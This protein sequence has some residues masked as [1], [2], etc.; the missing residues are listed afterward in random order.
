MTTPS[1]CTKCT[2]HRSRRCIVR[3]TIPDG[4]DVLFVGEA[5][6]AVEEDERKPFVG[7]AGAYLRTALLTA[8][9]DPNK[10]AYANSVRCRPPLRNRRQTR[11]TPKQ[12]AVCHDFLA[13]DVKRLKPKLIVALGAPA[14]EA[15]HRK[16]TIAEAR[17]APFACDQFGVPTIVTYHPSGVMQDYSDPELF[18]ADLRRAAQIASGVVDTSKPAKLGDYTVIAPGDGY[19]EKQ[20]LAGLQ[21]LRDYLLK[22]KR[23]SFDIESEGTNPR[24]HR[25]LCLS[26]STKPGEG[27]VVPLV[28]RFVECEGLSIEE[29]VKTIGVGGRT[30]RQVWSAKALE[31]VVE[32]LREI[33]ESDVPKT[34]Q[35][36][37]FD[38]RFC[39]L[40]LEIDVKAFDY[41]T[42]LA[43]HTYHS[44]RPHT[45]EHLRDKYTDMPQYDMEL[46]RYAP[47]RKHSF[48][49][50]PEEVLWMYSA[51][52]ADCEYQLGDA[53][54]KDMH[55]GPYANEA[56]EW[57]LNEISM[58]LQRALGDA[59]DKGIPVDEVYVAKLAQQVKDRIVELKAKLDR[60]IV[61][62]ELEPPKNYGSEQQLN[63]LFYSPAKP[64]YLCECRRLFYSPERLA[65]HLAWAEE[66]K[67]AGHRQKKHWL[68]GLGIPRDEGAMPRPGYDEKQTS[69]ERYHERI[70]PRRSTTERPVIAS[71][72]TDLKTLGNLLDLKAISRGAKRVL[73]EIIDLKQVEKLKS[74]FIGDEKQTKGWIRFVE[75]GW[76]H[77]TF[78][79]HGTETSRL[80]SAG[81]NVQNPPSAAV[82]RNIVRAKEGFKLVDA[83]YSQVENRALAYGARS[84]TYV[85]DMLSCATCGERYRY[86]PDGL[87]AHFVETQH[88][89]L[90][91]HTAGALRIF[92]VTADQV[93]PDIRF[94]AK[95]FTHGVNYGRGPS[96]VSEAF[97][98]SF[99]SAKEQIKDYFEKYPDIKRFHDQTRV[100]LDETSMALTYLGRER[101]F[102]TWRKLREEQQRDGRG[103]ARRTIGLI[104]HIHREAI[105]TF[106]Q[107]SAAELL[108]LATIGLFDWRG[109][110]E[111][112]D[113]VM[114]HRLLR[115]HFGEYPALVMQHEYGAHMAISMHDSL[116]SVAP[117]GFAEKV[118]QMVCD[119]M[120]RIPL[121]VIPRV[122][123]PRY[124]DWPEGW[125][126]PVDAKIHERYGTDINPT[127]GELLGRDEDL[128]VKEHLERSRVTIRASK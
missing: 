26:F 78:N 77:P 9:F 76:L 14:L 92:N 112:G 73:N 40:Q 67:E 53:T 55:E 96:A 123:S 35:L 100:W 126:L 107:G 41:D 124:G 119:V 56:A 121:L 31:R 61:K 25:M 52:D 10:V 20:A 16:M 65:K 18:Q 114:I 2:L 48:A 113:K 34:A 106:P 86:D 98:C 28:G 108:H 30:P 102:P 6:G 104:N 49:A 68:P 51:A 120:Y 7:P 59:S 15:V 79:V 38:V 62:L 24:K 29:I 70:R 42:C 13:E 128:N 5:P 60:V 4:A 46:K 93:T 22:A 50:A 32:I 81:P 90:D 33:L 97:G 80:S 72:G 125:Y 94:Q 88:K 117:D 74:T 116:L 23:F 66:E 3:P 12:I 71:A 89:R 82:F 57:L 101:H 17:G 115:K 39:H 83:D 103:T 75:N 99:D 111:Y 1:D 45:L 110:H 84:E 8:G 43:H 127:T 63:R 109:A 36:G 37:A 105:A 69:Q 11:P 19:T 54:F 118:K 44:R 64:S 87:E 95:T 85:S 21:D 122:S 91:M 58:P 27:F 47:T